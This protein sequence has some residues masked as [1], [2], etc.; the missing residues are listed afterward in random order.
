[1]RMQSAQRSLRVLKGTLRLFG[2]LL[3]AV[4]VWGALVFAW[5][6]WR[7]HRL[8]AFCAAAA[9]GTPMTEVRRLAREHGLSFVRDIVSAE[10][11]RPGLIIAR[12]M[13][14]AMTECAVRHD[15]R[16]VLEAKIDYP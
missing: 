7:G 14:P 13:T 8:H 5:G 12:E 16:V 9:P 15:G 6:A 11:G 1:M 10:P 4:L 3:L 2:M